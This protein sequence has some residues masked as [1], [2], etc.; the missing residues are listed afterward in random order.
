MMGTLDLVSSSDW[1]TI[2]PALLM[3]AEIEHMQFSV[4][5]LIQPAAP[6]DLVLIEPMWH[7]LSAA[8]R[9]FLGILR[10]EAMELNDRWRASSKQTA[11]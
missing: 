7:T 8:A 11:S 9:A 1:I 3:I 4:L 6:L 5:P 10:A 2:I